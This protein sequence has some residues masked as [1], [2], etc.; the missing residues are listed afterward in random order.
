LIKEEEGI[1]GKVLRSFGVNLLAVRQLTINFSIRPHF[2]GA[3]QKEKEKQILL[4]WM[5]LVET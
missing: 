5:N 4:H 3:P 1:A 2:H